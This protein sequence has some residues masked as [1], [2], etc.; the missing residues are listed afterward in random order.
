[1][2]SRK[3]NLSIDLKIPAPKE[4]YGGSREKIGD[5]PTKKKIKKL[6]SVIKEL[7][8]EKQSLELWKDKLQNKVKKWKAK[9]KEKC[10]F[11]SKVR[12]MN[13]NLYWGNIVLKTKLKQE[14]SKARCRF[15][16][17]VL[18]TST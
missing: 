5:E 8:H 14:K 16:D 15:K 3:P 11:S 13:I 2:R 1:M 6:Q 7:K 9:N 18:I 4:D 10:Q 12:K 17:Q